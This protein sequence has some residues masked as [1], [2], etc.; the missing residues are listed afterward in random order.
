MGIAGKVAKWISKFL[1]FYLTEWKLLYL[2][3]FMLFLYINNI[4]CEPIETYMDTVIDWLFCRKH[5]NR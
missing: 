2:F 1:L 5:K 3:L 4:L